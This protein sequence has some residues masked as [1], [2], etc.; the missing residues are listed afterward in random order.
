M[1]LGQHGRDGRAMPMSAIDPKRTRVSASGSCIIR[2]IPTEIGSPPL[3]L[4]V[5]LAVLQR[6]HLPG[7]RTR[8]AAPEDINADMLAFWNGKGGD[9]WVARQDYTDITLE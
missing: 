2:G 5:H 7:R 6:A 9:T 1:V 8:L 4:A 3:P